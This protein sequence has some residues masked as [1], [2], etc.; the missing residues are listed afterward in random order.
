MAGA[1]AA[2]SRAVALKPKL[3]AREQQHVDIFDAM[4]SGKPV[5]ARKKIETHVIEHPRD[6]LAA[7]ACTNVF[8]LI[9]F[10]GCPGREAD[11]LAYTA[12]LNPHYGE[13]WWMISM[14]ALSLCETGHSGPALELMERSLELN[15]ANAN[16]SHFKSH[17]QYE[18]GM[19]DVGLSYL[20][21][22]LPGYDRRGILHGHLSWHLALWAL[23]QGELDLMWQTVDNAIAPGASESLPINVLTDTAALYWRAELAGVDVAAE[24]WKTLSDYATKTFP[25]PGQ[26]F[27]DIHAAL[28]HAA[29]GEGTRL[30]KIAETKSGYAGDLV[31]PVARAWRAIAAQQWH[32]ALDELT[33]VMADHARLGG[34]RAQ[35]DILELTYLNVLMRLGRGEEAQRMVKM[36]RPVFDGTVPVAGL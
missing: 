11:L 32:S 21:D 19:R 36:R 29:A 5:E 13:D 9:G 1:K 31:V 8:G 30:A 15:N 26:S 25:N 20:Q 16:A 2:I 3:N 18:A 24:R 35:R 10:S 27:A 33:P 12:W 34:S 22:W 17:A 28:S 23:H 6:A 14:H 4:L 7:Q